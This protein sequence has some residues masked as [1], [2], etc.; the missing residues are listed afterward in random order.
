MST[1]FLRQ[2]A[3]TSIMRAG[4]DTVSWACIYA[5]NMSLS[6]RFEQ[7][8]INELMEAIHE[9][10]RMLMSWSPGRLREIRNHLGCFNFDRYPESPDL[11][12]YF[13]K[14]LTDY[15]NAEQAGGHQSPKRPESE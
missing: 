9:V 13:D 8:A 14:R 7:S 10:P 12:A 3:P 5:R 11:V 1:V 15:T 4:L 6:D 2:L